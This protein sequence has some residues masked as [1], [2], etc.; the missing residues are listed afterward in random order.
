MKLLS[1][2]RKI[3][4]YT[5]RQ[6][7]VAEDQL[8]VLKLIHENQ[9]LMLDEMRR[10][11]EQEPILVPWTSDHMSCKVCG[12]DFSNGAMGYVCNNP[13]CPSAVRCTSHTST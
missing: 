13:N 1:L 3:C 7:K 8:K 4:R 12:L 10:K 2:L 11:P 6:S 5:S 9:K